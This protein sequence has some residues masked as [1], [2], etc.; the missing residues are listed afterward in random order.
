MKCLVLGQG[1]LTMIYKRICID[2]S[3]EHRHVVFVFEERRS[4]KYTG[5]TYIYTQTRNIATVK[6]RK[7]KGH[8]KYYIS[9]FL[10]RWHSCMSEFCRMF[11]Q[12]HEHSCASLSYNG[13]SFRDCRS[14]CRNVHKMCRC[15]FIKSSFKCD[16]M[17]YL[18]RTLH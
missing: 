6:N 15:C 16:V 7:Y 2:Y 3:L 13:I 18:E 11:S 17:V 10:G 5:P 8:N 9:P 1:H 12:F 14:L 4:I